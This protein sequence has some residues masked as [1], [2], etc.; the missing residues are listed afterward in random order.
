MVSEIINIISNY[1]NVPREKI[2]I[3]SR[4]IADLELQSMDVYSLI[5]EIE[6]K[7]GVEIED[8]EIMEVST[9]KD[10][11]LLIIKKMKNWF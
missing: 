11:E 9:I 7:F 1:T 8:Y 4:I 6:D 5:S 3:N 10:I 2:S